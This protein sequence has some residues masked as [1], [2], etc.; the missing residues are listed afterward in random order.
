MPSWLFQA[1]DSLFTQH[2][3]AVWSLA[4]LTAW[5][6]LLIA[7]TDRGVVRLAMKHPAMD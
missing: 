7:E 1:A 6:A 5:I 2:F 3:F 4:R